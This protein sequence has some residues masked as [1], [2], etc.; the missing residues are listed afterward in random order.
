MAARV[1][2]VAFPYMAELSASVGYEVNLGLYE[3]PDVVFL[4]KVYVI[5]GRVSSILRFGR[6]PLLASH[7]GRT[8]VAF[9]P[10]GV[11][12]ALL[13]SGRTS[14]ESSVP[15]SAEAI[16]NELAQIRDRGY[17]AFD[18]NPEFRAPAGISVPIVGPDALAV[19]GLTITRT[20]PLS[21]EFL[22]DVL[23]KAMHVSQRISGELGYH[24]ES[25]AQ[26]I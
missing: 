5:S 19:A 26:V 12:E 13:A 2:D 21:D 6:R 25:A 11:A 24:S 22:H 10:P 20:T 7:S 4:E 9:R 1:R 17:I 14:D 23:P 15:M 18:R 3:Y 16:R 8:M